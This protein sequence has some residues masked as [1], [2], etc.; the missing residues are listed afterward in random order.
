[1]GCTGLYWCQHFDFDPL[2][3][4]SIPASCQC[5][6]PDVSPSAEP[7]NKKL[8]IFKEVVRDCWKQIPL[9]NLFSGRRVYKSKLCQEKWQI[10]PQ[11]Q[12]VET[13]LKK[14]KDKGRGIWRLCETLGETQDYYSDTIDNL[15]KLSNV[16][17]QSKVRLSEKYFP[18]MLLRWALRCFGRSGSRILM[19]TTGRSP[20]FTPSLLRTGG[21]WRRSRK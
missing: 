10:S 20:T 21:F 18:R 8:L 14:H 19:F 11:F 9:L 12:A 4:N 3:Y 17:L 15:F 7:A 6:Y 1:M 13:H 16:L 5:W 2:C